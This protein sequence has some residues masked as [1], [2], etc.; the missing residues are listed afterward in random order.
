MPQL[1][2][3]IARGQTIPPSWP[4]HLVPAPLLLTIPVL[5]LPRQ[6]LWQLSD[7]TLQ[8]AVETLANLYP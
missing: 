6:L 8:S 1:S 3:V 2:S 5:Q 4:H 7:T